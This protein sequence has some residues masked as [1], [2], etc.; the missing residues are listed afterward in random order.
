MTDAYELPGLSP[1]EVS[2]VL[3]ALGRIDA[4]LTL[5]EAEA[6][7]TAISSAF[8][9]CRKYPAL[10]CLEG[11]AREAIAQAGCLQITEFELVGGGTYPRTAE[12]LYTEDATR[13]AIA[14]VL[15]EGVPPSQ[16]NE[17]AVERAYPTRVQALRAEIDLLVSGANAVLAL[18][19]E[20]LARSGL[21]LPPE[22]EQLLQA[23][24]QP[25]LYDSYEQVNKLRKAANL[26]AKEAGKRQPMLGLEADHLVRSELLRDPA[27]NRNA[28]TRLAEG[29]ATLLSDGQT[30]GTQHRYATDRQMAWIRAQRACGAKPTLA[31]ALCAAQSWMTDIY[32]RS[33]LSIDYIREPNVD[34]GGISR[35]EKALAEKGFGLHRGGIMRRGER[36]ALAAANAVVVVHA[37]MRH[38]IN[39]G[40]QLDDVLPMFAAT[41]TA[42]RKGK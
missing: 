23:L 1:A 25:Q 17:K 7:A 8:S 22:S 13:Q 26:A 24:V 36:H 9:L 28:D 11:K 21:P 42:R 18:D 33:E 35:S 15:A 3:S 29:F 38:F 19:F 41:P 30:A 20:A 27:V 10:K 32:F 6:G 5:R 4:N 12:Q 40:Y 39:L 37:A 31:D 2:T 34:P 14:R 16:I